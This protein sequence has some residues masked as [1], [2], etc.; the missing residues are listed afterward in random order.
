MAQIT[1][2]FDRDGN[3]VPI[4]THGLKV[5]K[6]IAFDGG[7]GTGAQGAIT[8]F[9]VTGQVAL[10]VFAICTEDLASSGGTIEVGTA[11]STAALCSQITATNFDNHESWHDSNQGLGIVVGGHF[12]VIN[13][14]IILTVATADVTDGTVDFYC[15]WTPLS[16][17]SSV[18][19]A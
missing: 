4:W 3:R 10:N 2:T 8:L 6:N 19:A 7:S 15:Y 1:A 13:E 9:T 11:T 5:S 17:G 18:V 12:H 16:S 14:D